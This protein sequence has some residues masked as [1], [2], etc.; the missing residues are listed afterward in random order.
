MVT[1]ALAADQRCVVVALCGRNDRA[2]RR[3]EGLAR[4]APRLRVLGWV[5]DTAG[6]TAAV[7][8]VVNNA[9]GVTAQEALARGRALVMFR[10]LAGH[11]RDSALALARAGVAERC[12]NHRELTHLLRAYARDP[13]RLDAA[14]RRAARYAGRHG[15]D[16]LAATLPRRP[17]HGPDRRVAG[18]PTGHPD[19][20]GEVAR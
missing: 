12:R 19:V 7:D 18:R 3:L 20:T 13:A 2:R 9:G 4:T 10:P 15:L 17:T 16:D 8:V 1:A 5:E 11:G 14:Q 6:L